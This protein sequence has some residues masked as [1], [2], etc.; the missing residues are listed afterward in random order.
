MS[1]TGGGDAVVSCVDESVCG[2]S[3]VMTAGELNVCGY[4]S[5]L[6]DEAGNSSRVEVAVSIDDVVACG[7][8][9]LLP[10][11]VRVGGRLPVIGDTLVGLSRVAGSGRGYT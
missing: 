6:S 7:D 9:P 1:L 3:S 10:D 11:A 8:D 5:V 2:I 4:H